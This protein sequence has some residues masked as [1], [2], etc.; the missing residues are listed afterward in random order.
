[1]MKKLLTKI[2]KLPISALIFCL[3][4]FTL[5]ALNA[6]PSPKEIVLFLEG[7][8]YNYG[9]NMKFDYTDLCHPCPK[10]LRLF[11]WIIKSVRPLSVID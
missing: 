10:P 11:E 6:I 1:M 2:P 7:L 4:F 8:Y 5:V 9:F 3:T